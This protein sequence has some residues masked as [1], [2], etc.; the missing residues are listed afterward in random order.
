MRGGKSLDQKTEEEEEERHSGRQ[1]GQR[2]QSGDE[3]ARR[4]AMGEGDVFVDGASSGVAARIERHRPS[5]TQR[6]Q[7]SRQRHEWSSGASGAGDEEA[8]QGDRDDGSNRQRLGDDMGG[9]ER[10]LSQ[11]DDGASLAWRR[12]A[13]WGSPSLVFGWVGPVAHLSLLPRHSGRPGRLFGPKAERRPTSFACLF[14]EFFSCVDAE[15][16][17][18]LPQVLSTVFLLTKS[19]SAISRV[20]S[21]SVASWATR[22]SAGVRASRPLRGA[23]RGRAPVADSSA[24]HRCASAVAPQR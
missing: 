20:V 5:Q 16:G 18:H 11:E 8:H 19:A 4:L 13:I 7:E 24:Q 14:L 21:P 15:L 17:V 23:R 6:A 9:G 22:S 1:H 2:R 10:W 3:N 12:G